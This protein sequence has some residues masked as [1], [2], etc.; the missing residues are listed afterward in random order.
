MKDVLREWKNIPDSFGTLLLVNGASGEGAKRG[1]NGW[2][3]AVGEVTG[4]RGSSF[5]FNV[6]GLGLCNE[7]Q[8]DPDRPM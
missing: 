4:K 5:P 8:Q 1:R 7:L 6:A 3:A 2:G